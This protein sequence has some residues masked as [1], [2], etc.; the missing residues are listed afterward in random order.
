MYEICRQVLEGVIILC[1]VVVECVVVGVDVNID[2][3]L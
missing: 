2:V 1:E 3:C